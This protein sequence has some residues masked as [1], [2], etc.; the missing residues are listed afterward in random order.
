MGAYPCVLEEDS[1]AHRV[2]GVKE[3]S[4]RHRHRYEFNREYEELLS[5]Y[6]LRISGTSPDRNFVEIVEVENH[7]WFLACQFH[8]E[9]KSKPLN[10]HPLFVS[11]IAAALRHKKRRTVPLS[12]LDGVEEPVFSRK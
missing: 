6:G 8:P 5:S 9:F 1:L 2:Y 12:V 3:I 10:P 4:E 7:P 11:F